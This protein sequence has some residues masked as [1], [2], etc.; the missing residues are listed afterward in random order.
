MPR[1]DRLHHLAGCHLVLRH[2][3][4]LSIE[5]YRA[6]P[7]DRLRQLHHYQGTIRRLVAEAHP[8][9]LRALWPPDPEVHWLV[10]LL[11]TDPS[12]RLLSVTRGPLGGSH[13]TLLAVR[14]SAEDPASERAAWA[15]LVKVLAKMDARSKS[16]P[17]GN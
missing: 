7:P 10:A 8:D 12:V 17:S 11:A 14:Y 16:A 1:H 13:T 15:A 2:L 4:L 9:V 5:A 3:N 6:A